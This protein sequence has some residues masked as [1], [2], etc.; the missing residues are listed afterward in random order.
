[1]SYRNA[2]ESMEWGDTI[3]QIT[4]DQNLKLLFS[5]MT[6]ILEIFATDHRIDRIKLEI[7]YSN[8]EIKYFF[9]P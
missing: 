5:L 6:K 4:N 3:E 7:N 2:D 1:M 9:V 8:G